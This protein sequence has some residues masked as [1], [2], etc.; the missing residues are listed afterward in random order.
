MGLV[1]RITVGCLFA[2]A[3]ATAG[4]KTQIP[5]PKVIVYFCFIGAGMIL[6]DRWFL[7]KK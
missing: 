6:L 7:E 1:K 4:F 3:G 2:L 5:L